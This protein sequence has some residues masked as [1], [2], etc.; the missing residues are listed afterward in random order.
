MTRQRALGAL[1]LLCGGCLYAGAI[2]TVLWATALL[3]VSP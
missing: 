1:R 3:H 2:L